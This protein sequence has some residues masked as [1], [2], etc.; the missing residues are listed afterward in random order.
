MDDKDELVAGI[1]IEAFSSR[2]IS[3]RVVIDAYKRHRC[4]DR[5]NDLRYDRSHACIDHCS[6]TLNAK[7]DHGS[8]AYSTHNVSTLAPVVNFQSGFAA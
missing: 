3:D 1:V 7:S 6:Q 8:G 5:K 2:S 4:S